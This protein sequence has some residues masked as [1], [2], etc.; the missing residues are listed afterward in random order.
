MTYL[1]PSLLGDSNDTRY[2][3]IGDRSDT[4]ARWRSM[5]IQPI[6]FPQESQSDYGGLD[7]AVAGLA[8]HTRRG[9][10]DWQREITN[11]ASA[12]PPFDEESAGVIEHALSTPELAQFFT[13]AAVSPD[14]LDWLDRRGLMD[15]LFTDGKLSEQ[16][17]MLAGWIASR[18]ALTYD[19]TLFALIERHGSRPNPT[20]WWQLCWQMQHSI[21]DSPD[22]AAMTRWVLFLSGVTPANAD[23]IALLWIAKAAASVGAT[24]ALL[25]TYE[26][27][28][29]LIN[30][31]LPR[32]RRS[33]DRYHHELKTMLVQ[34]FKPNLSQMAESLLEITARRLSE[35]HSALA[36]W[37]Q[38]E[39]AWDSDS[40]SRS[41]IEPHS[42][43]RFNDDID[44]LIEVARECLDWLAA[45]RAEYARLWSER[46][47]SSQAPLLR[48]LAV[49]TLTELPGL[50]AD[51]KIAW[52]LER[53]DVN[54]SAAKH[55]IFRAARKAYPHASKEL[56]EA[57][58]QVVLDFRLPEREGYDSVRRS[59]GRH[60]EWLHWL[61][62]SA[63][64]CEPTKKALDGVWGRYPEF[65]PS[66][67]PD[68]LMWSKTWAGVKS[69]WTSEALLASPVAEI[70]P[71]LLE[72]QPT[73]R[74]N[75][76]ASTA[77]QCWIM[78]EKRPSRTRIGVLIWRTVW[79]LQVNGSQTYGS[80]YFA[81]GPRRK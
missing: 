10:L 25:R 50:S 22:T 23:D 37:R 79:Q 73:D 35:R 26:E 32:G 60:F 33:S 24:D 41:A 69:P 70:L 78:L 76:M 6:T 66:E 36:A 47:A 55:E 75:S 42:Q 43:D 40:I 58:I 14:W 51:E 9:I 48:R 15:T 29:A 71:S 20:V 61:H 38:S 80:A 62:E 17:R 5:G 44:A 31:G 53:C 13:G 8:N 52:L 34:C 77:R 11:I 1:T 64:D 56:R 7:K 49:H 27:M 81:L 18:F 68:L 59:A 54:E 16:E 45:N 28:T 2:A 19:R 12:P 74:E 57:L 30:R 65:L 39:S 63:P 3:L 72:Y 21:P 4:P 67:H 46:H